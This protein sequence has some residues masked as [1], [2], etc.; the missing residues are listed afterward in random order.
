MHDS[1]NVA[2]AFKWQHLNQIGCCEIFYILFTTNRIQ[3][4]EIVPSY[5][6][7]WYD[8]NGLIQLYVFQAKRDAQ[9]VGH[10][11]FHKSQGYKWH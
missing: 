1:D 6:N 11:G 5:S 10:F 3:A 8:P 7:T 2:I 9:V 4:R